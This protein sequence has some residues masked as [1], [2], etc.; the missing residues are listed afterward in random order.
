MEL[1]LDEY[2]LVSKQIDRLKAE[3]EQVLLQTDGGI[4]LSIPG[5]GVTTAA[6]L[7]AEMGDLSMFTRPEQ[8]IK[9]AGPIRLLNNLV[10][11]QAFTYHISKQGR[12]PFRAALI[13]LVEV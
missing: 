11:K 6:E 4:L 8:L 2:E 1:K 5:V 13:V 9:M 10:D 12:A 7:T 3:M